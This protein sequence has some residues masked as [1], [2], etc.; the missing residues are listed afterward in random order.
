MNDSYNYTDFLDL[1]SD[2]NKQDQLL[3][4]KPPI[5][6]DELISI[7]QNRI[8]DNQLFSYVLARIDSIDR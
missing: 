6:S 2:D 4:N 8:A 3:K 7:T 5:Q 1:L